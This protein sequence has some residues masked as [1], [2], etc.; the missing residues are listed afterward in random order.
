[1]ANA[2]H[3][4]FLSMQKGLLGIWD[5]VKLHEKVTY[6]SVHSCILNSMK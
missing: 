4:L 5:Y 3:F 1:V 2:H 6:D